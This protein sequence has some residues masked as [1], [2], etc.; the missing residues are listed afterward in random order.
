[1]LMQSEDWLTDTRFGGHVLRDVMPGLQLFCLK[2]AS[3]RSKLLQ[4]LGQW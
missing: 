2:A 1:M 3:V 4:T